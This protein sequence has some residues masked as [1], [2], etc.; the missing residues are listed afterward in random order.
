MSHD[1]S[2]NDEK[3]SALYR[4]HAADRPGEQPSPAS[5]AFVLEMARAAVRSSAPVIKAPLTKAN[6]WRAWLSAPWLGPGLAFATIASLSIVVVSLMPNEEVSTEREVAASAS[7]GDAAKKSDVTSDAGPGPS[8]ESSAA[9]SK[10][11]SSSAAAQATPTQRATAT[12]SVPSQQPSPREAPNDL[13]RSRAPESS[14]K[15]KLAADGGSGREKAMRER[16]ERNPLVAGAASS[17]LSSAAPRAAPASA[18]T[19]APPPPAR[20][21]AASPQS[22]S[23]LA[24]SESARYE[25]PS[26]QSEP[27]ESRLLNQSVAEVPDSAPTY[28]NEARPSIPLPYTYTMPRKSRDAAAGPGAA[29][30]APSRPQATPSLAAAAPARDPIEWVKTIQKLR[31]EGKMDQVLKELAEF[32][33]VHP[34]YALPE[35]LRNLK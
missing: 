32:R 1:P 9:A 25:K 2:E 6:G 11:A 13:R 23:P 20:A 4:A 7:R 22:P 24:S 26:L 3:L 35:D 14:A 16:T 28:P 8:S 17:S 19:S 10:A 34:Q 31:T 12:E 21:T 33:K 29:A 15:A 27:A 18:P 30:G 5:D